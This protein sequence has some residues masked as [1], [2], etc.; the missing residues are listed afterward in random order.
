MCRYLLSIT[1]KVISLALTN[2]PQDAGTAKILGP[3][4]HFELRRWGGL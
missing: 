4:P 1:Y 3:K 2:L